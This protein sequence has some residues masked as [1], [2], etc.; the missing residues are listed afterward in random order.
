MKKNMRKFLHQKEN[1]KT[2]FEENLE[3]KRDY[4]KKQK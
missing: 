2:Q 1:M 3:A 4:E